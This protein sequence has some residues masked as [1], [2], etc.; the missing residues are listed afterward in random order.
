MCKVLNVR[1]VGRRPAPDRVYVGRPRT[2]H[3][4]RSA[5]RT[6]RNPRAKALSSLRPSVR[7]EGTG[8]SADP[9]EIIMSPSDGDFDDDAQ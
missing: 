1:K 8:N 5:F 9:G 4:I 2:A 7:E 6:A 3:R